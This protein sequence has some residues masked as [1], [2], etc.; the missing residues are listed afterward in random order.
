VIHTSYLK[1]FSYV[2]VSSS[3]CLDLPLSN[4]FWSE[5]YRNHATFE[6]CASVVLLHL[7]LSL[8]D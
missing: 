2:Q 5:L 3:C 8:P 4:V 6:M 7:K 1:A